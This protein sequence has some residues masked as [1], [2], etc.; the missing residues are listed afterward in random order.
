MARRRRFSTLLGV[1][2]GDGN[3]NVMIGVEWYKREA[4]MQVDREFWRNGWADPAQRER[5]LLDGDGLFAGRR[6][7]RNRDAGSGAEPAH[8]GGRRRI[9]HRGDGSGLRPRDGSQQQRD[10]LQPGRHAV[11]LDRRQLPRPVPELH[12][13]R[14]RVRGRSAPTERHVGAERDAGVCGDAGRA[15]LGV[16][17][18]PRR[19]QRQS[20]RLRA[21]DLQQHCRQ[22]ARR[23]PARDHG[24][25]GVCPERRP[26]AAAAGA[27]DAAELAHARPGRC[28]P[29][30]GRRSDRP[31]GCGRSVDDFPR[32][33]LHGWP[34]RAAERDQRLP[35]HGGRRGPVREPRLDVGRLRLDWPDRDHQHL[36]QPHVAAALSVPRRP[37]AVGQLGSGPDVHQG[38]KLHAVL[39]HRPADV[40]DGRPQRRLHRGHRARSCGRR[41]ISRRTSSKRT[42]RARSPT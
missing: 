35:A 23:L 36:Q 18:R 19:P 22:D 6:R 29:A 20:D 25:A 2:G 30:A 4:V 3:S 40:L 37:T 39:R 12:C 14:R 8:P 15:A 31:V 9:V 32:H 24:L 28:G 7:C 27:A 26:A 16:R 10:L 42:C 21:G 38:P 13:E 17:A 34:E 11:H 1:N 41:G 33:R 5:R